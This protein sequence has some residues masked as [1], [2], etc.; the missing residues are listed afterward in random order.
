MEMSSCDW[1]ELEDEA[2][3]LRAVEFVELCVVVRW[4]EPG[5]LGFGQH[6]SSVEDIVLRYSLFSMLLMKKF[7]IGTISQVGR[8]WVWV[9][10]I[11]GNILLSFLGVPLSGARRF[12]GFSCLSSRSELRPI[13]LKSGCG[14]L[15]RIQVSRLKGD[16]IVFERYV[17][18]V[19]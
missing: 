5:D 9:S 14:G 2:E 7:H 12:E 17:S 8:F 10:E 3:V 11:V 15:N 19:I 6:V 13:L 16:V 18:F 1:H 4:T